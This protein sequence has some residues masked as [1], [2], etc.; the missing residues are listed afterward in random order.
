MKRILLSLLL[1]SPALA[2]P[3]L[4]EAKAA[5]QQGD[6]AAAETLL[7]PLT[8]AE[9]PDPAALHQLA[10]LRQRQG[11]PKD[12]VPLLERATALDA[13]KADYFAALG[14][15]VSEA[16]RGAPMMEMAA[17]SGKVR[18]AF[19]K[20]VELDPNH[21]TGLIGLTRY[22]SNAPEM[23]GGSLE[24]AAE[25]ALRI[26]KL[27]P[28]LGALERGNIAER[29]EDYAAALP[30]YEAALKLKPDHAGAQAGLARVR[31]KLGQK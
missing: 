28:L 8:A 20:A 6:L 18:K 13:T 23:A 17:L 4:D 22:Y 5:F 3:A 24:K 11:R 25:L 1:T 14:I 16:M 26:E 19:A 2:I 29:G 15:A 31:E 27:N 9:K 7:L 10:L 30:H 21:V 12:A